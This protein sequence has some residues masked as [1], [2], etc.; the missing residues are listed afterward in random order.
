MSDEQEEGEEVKTYDP[1]LADHGEAEMRE[2]PMGGYVTFYDYNSL[3]K[4]YEK[5]LK[6]IQKFE[7]KKANS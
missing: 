3:M 2:D 1:Y 6:K 4:L 5:A 7:K